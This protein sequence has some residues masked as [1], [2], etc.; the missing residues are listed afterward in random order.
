V[1]RFEQVC[2][3]LGEG[4]VR[5]DALRGLDLEVPSGQMC[6]L[7]GPSGAGKSTLLQ[8]AAGLS[9]SDSGEVYVGDARLSALSSDE[10]TLLRRRKI[11]VVFQFFNLL[12]YLTA[13]QN[14][15]FPLEID[16]VPAA[17]CH[18]RTRRVLASVDMLHREHHFPHMLSGGE[19]QRV[20]IAR[21][22]VIDP[23]VVLAD[24]PTGNLDSRSA[25][26]VMELLRDLNRKTG[27]TVLVVTHDAAWTELCDRVVRLV[28]GRIVE[29]SVP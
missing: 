15:S 5:V 26:V 29:E 8:V 6:V 25:R 24:E 18:E 28:D 19:M 23:T 11:G 14:V 13:A 12:P 7:M 1:L 17:E 3:A 2:K 21:A 20:A 10:L 4:V 22:V 27:V 9:Q 16:A